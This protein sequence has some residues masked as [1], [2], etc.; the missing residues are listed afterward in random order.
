MELYYEDGDDDDQLSRFAEEIL[1]EF[2]RYQASGGL[3]EEFRA[4]LERVGRITLK[5]V[6][7]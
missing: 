4:V 1:S 7:E 6:R 2:E 5:L 3:L